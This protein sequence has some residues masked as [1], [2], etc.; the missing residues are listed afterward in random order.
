MLGNVEAVTMPEQFRMCALHISMKIFKGVWGH[1]GEGVLALF[2]SLLSLFPFRIF[3]FLIKS[4]FVR[5]DN[6]ASLLRIQVSH[7]CG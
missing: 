7:W 2:L 1:V 4:F 3:F 6:L 5:Y